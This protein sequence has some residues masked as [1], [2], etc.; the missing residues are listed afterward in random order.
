MVSAVRRLLIGS[1]IGLVLSVLLLMVLSPLAARWYINS[2]LPKLIGIDVSVGDID[3][4]WFA[5]SVTVDQVRIARFEEA[6]LLVSESVELD[7]DVLELLDNR[8]IVKSVEFKGTDLDIIRADGN[9]NLAQLISDVIESVSSTNTTLV[10]EPP[11]SAGGQ[12][13][14]VDVLNIVLDDFV[15][16]FDD[17]ND[18]RDTQRLLDLGYLELDDLIIDI[19]ASTLTLRNLELDNVESSIWRDGNGLMDLEIVINEILEETNVDTGESLESNVSDA[20]TWDISV[21]QFHLKEYVVN[22]NDVSQERPVSLS[23]GPMTLELAEFSTTN[24]SN[25]VF[26]M[27]SG[28][29]NGGVLAVEGSFSL[30]SL[31]AS[32]DIRFND[33]D[34]SVM[35]PYIDTSTWIDIQDGDLQIDGN[36]ALDLNDFTDPDVRYVGSASVNQL[37]LSDRRDG[38]LIAGHE[39]LSVTGLDFSLR[40]LHLAAESLTLNDSKLVLSISPDGSFSLLDL[41]RVSREELEERGEQAKEIGQEFRFS[42]DD[43]AVRNGLFTFSDRSLTTPFAMNLLIESVDVRSFDSSSG[44]DRASARINFGRAGSSSFD[45]NTAD[46]GITAEYSIEGLP[47]ANVS[48]YVAAFTGYELASGTFNLNGHFEL[49]QRILSMDNLI[50]A[51]QVKVGAKIR[52][53]NTIPLPLAVTL[54][55]DLNGNMSLDLPVS[56][57]LDDPNFNVIGLTADVFTQAILSAVTSPLSMLGS[58]VGRSD[59]DLIEF[60]P[61]SSELS[62]ETNSRLAALASALETKPELILRITPTS[63][64]VLDSRVLAPEIVEAEQGSVSIAKAYED[65]TG[66][67]SASLTESLKGIDEVRKTARAIE[68][69]VQQ[70]DELQ[71]ALHELA[72]ARANRVRDL[73]TDDFGVP[74]NRIQVINPVRTTAPGRTVRLEV[75]VITK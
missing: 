6:P 62:D 57:S 29:P 35:Q 15:I 64:A 25:A 51:Q 17:L 21:E 41:A 67:S 12:S 22:F 60:E 58:I 5:T 65:L 18:E 37:K 42:V 72:D 69:I 11:S 23:F 40:D 53:E 30:M 43:I 68:L 61:G 54:L 28:T 52:D 7:I 66:L 38:S 26:S 10:Q 33:F 31:L 34:L 3:V 45:L 27:Q 24:E 19:D 14:H 1:L 9:H 4:H 46:E 73:L 71:A 39:S 47:M 74:A 55:S 32:V 44:L 70:S 59:L 20:P 8:I 2:E 63:H 13:W 16:S 36:V 49:S 48:G 50:L 56:G 75:D